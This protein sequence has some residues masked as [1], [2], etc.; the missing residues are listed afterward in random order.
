[1]VGDLP[2]ESAL[3]L[4]HHHDGA[5]DT[6]EHRQRSHRSHEGCAFCG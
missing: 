1:M 5:D 4:S 6:E 3:P 2:S